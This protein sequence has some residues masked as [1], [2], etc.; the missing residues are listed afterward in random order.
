MG[1]RFTTASS[2]EN[3]K[4]GLEQRQARAALRWL[5]G[6]DWGTAA[7]VVEAM[8]DCMKGLDLDFFIDRW[9]RRSGARRVQMVRAHLG[10][11]GRFS[12]GAL[13]DRQRSVLVDYLRT[14][15]LAPPNRGAP[16]S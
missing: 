14:H 8:P 3:L 7:D 6:G 1:T 9:L 12:L 13:S 2:R 15:E 10:V 11:R 5:V 4:R 16:L